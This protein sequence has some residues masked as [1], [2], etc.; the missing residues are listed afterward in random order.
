MTTPPRVRTFRRQRKESILDVQQDAGRRAAADLD[1]ATAS[2]AAAM[3][4]SQEE[5]SLK[6]RIEAVK[7]E[8]L[9]G[10]QLRLARRIAAM[11]G[12]DVDSDEE[13]VVMLRD[14]GVDPFHRSSLANV[15][16]SAGVSG[17]DDQA[18]AEQ[19]QKRSR[20]TGSQ[21]ALR[22]EPPVPAGGQALGQITPVKVP[23][24]RANLPSRE[25][26]TEERRAAEII[27]IQRDIARRRRI[28]Q[29]W[30]AVRLLLM[31]GI[32]TIIA[33][34]YYFRV[35]TPLYESRSQFL[36]QQADSGAE[37]GGGSMLSGVMTNPDSVSVQSY[38]VSKNAMLRLDEE[39][40]FREAF[41]DPAL[42]PLLRLPPDASDD[43]AFKLYKDMVSVSY[44]P[45]EGVLDMD[46]VAPDPEL[47]RDF[48][49]SLISYAE[50]MVDDMTTRIRDDQMQGAQQNYESAE[51]S[52]RD[53]QAAVQELQ[54][55]MGVLDAASESSLVMSRIGQLQSTLTEKQLELAQLRSNPNP[56]ASR[57]QGVQ[58]DIDRL[59]D[60]MEETRA[61]MTE[62]S[63]S[64]SSLAQVSGRLRI[65]E[66]DL[67][68]RQGLL[69]TAAEQLELARVEAN[70]Q[71]RYLSLSIAP[72]AAE[73]A[74]YPKALSN[75]I[76][77]F[78]IFMGIY[79]MLSL[80]ASIL[81]EQVST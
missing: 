72:L 74:T 70:K 13:A 28:R 21:L 43:D 31:V 20:A 41:Q 61:E 65:A 68:I 22:R 52:V 55:Q 4:D 35:A 58:G 1:A 27:R 63:E 24:D 77:A 81:R 62:S 19:G 29:F 15:L 66:A 47:S 32:P 60:L 7:S 12:I 33:G 73:D 40:G 38:L 79:L 16:A 17:A 26:M 11:H 18:K 39:N 34:W 2:S 64:R 80:T 25:E 57:V 78:L 5:P 45:T 46:V 37:T 30:L 9:T 49:L 14:R 36:I 8:E 71:V 23:A 42:D 53:A 51:Q 54:E 76:V 59:R 6:A 48:S 50:G 75:T 67:E 10:R 3:S 69:A 44:D 56:N